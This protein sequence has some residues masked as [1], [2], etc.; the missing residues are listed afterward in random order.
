MQSIPGLLIALV[1]LFSAESAVADDLEAGIRYAGGTRV[2]DPGTGISLILPA[3]WG[4]ILTNGARSL[5]LDSALHPGLGLIAW[6]TDVAADELLA[7]LAEPQALDEAYVLQP[8]ASPTRDG[9]VITARYRSGEACGLIVAV[10]G[11]DGRAVIVLL[12]GPVT[13]AAY[14]ATVLEQLRQSVRFDE[15]GRNHQETPT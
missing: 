15:A 8:E 9:D 14:Y 3:E 7:E 5:T 1:V 6:R 4:A 13:R 2:R 10:L 11:P 12:T